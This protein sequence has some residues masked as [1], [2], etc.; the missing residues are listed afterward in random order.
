MNDISITKK[1]LHT[2]G[3]QSTP[4]IWI[5]EKRIF[6]SKLWKVSDK[7][8][9]VQNKSYDLS[10][11]APNHPGGK[12]WIELTRGHDITE[13]FIA[14]HLNEEKARNVLQ[15]YFVSDV[16]NPQKPRYTFDENGLFR[17]TKKR[18]LK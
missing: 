16:A 9:I 10:A 15:K 12:Q 7:L 8:W 11:F 4:E 13:H 1:A 6:D 14:H 2:R 5:K 3:L 17:Q 18:L